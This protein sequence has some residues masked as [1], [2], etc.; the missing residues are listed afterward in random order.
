MPRVEL[1]KR[2]RDLRDSTL[3]AIGATKFDRTQGDMLMGVDREIAEITAQSLCARVLSG[4]QVT[5]DAL[6]RALAENTIVHYRGHIGSNSEQG[7][8]CRS[9]SSSRQSAAPAR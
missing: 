1:S 5:P 4:E 6:Q 9:R 3:L 7:V 2:T 8:V